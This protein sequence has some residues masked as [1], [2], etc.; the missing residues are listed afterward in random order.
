MK[1]IILLVL[2]VL[3]LGCVHHHSDSRHDHGYDDRPRHQ[4]HQSDRNRNEGHGR[5]GWYDGR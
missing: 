5:G 2:C 1:K 3:S 4:D